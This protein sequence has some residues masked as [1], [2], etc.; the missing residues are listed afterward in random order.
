VQ[1]K[2]WQESVPWL[3][4]VR[5]S[6]PYWIVRSLS[7]IPIAAG[8]VLVLVGLTTGTRGAGVSVIGGTTVDRKP[9]HVEPGR[10]EGNS[11]GRGLVMA[12]V[13]ACVA[14]IGFFA[15]SVSLLGV[16]PARVLADQ[17]AAMAPQSTLPLTVSELRGRQVYAREGCAYCHTQQ[18]RYLEADIARFGAPTLAWEGRHDYPH[19]MGTRR[20]GPDLSRTGGTRTENWHFVHLYAPRSVVP[21]S[22][23]PSYAGLFE[24]APDRPSQEARDLVAYLESLGRARELAW[25][26]GD[27]AALAAAV[28]DKWARMSLEAPMLNAH[29]AKTRPAVE[30]PALPTGGSAEAGRA[31][32]IT[33]CTGCHGEQGRGDGPAAAWLTPAPTNL[34]ARAFTNEHLANVL[35]NGVHNTAMPARRELSPGDLADLVAL[36]NEMAARPTEVAADANLA[37][38]EDVYLR[39]CVECHGENGG[40]DGFAAADLPVRPGNFRGVQPTFEESLRILSNGVKGS[41]MAQWNDRLNADEMTAVA[42]YVRTFF[43]AGSEREERR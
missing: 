21:Q 6:R 43:N 2:L 17:T 12:Y 1:G 9:V 18:I 24:G 35:W 22:I 26:D 32:W 30:A 23:M 28:N 42:H 38:G 40:G 36:V 20:I 33:N 10:V 7:A 5:A 39:N 16:L 27:K 15:L 19:L 25:P 41:S 13:V 4:S 8:F 3:E 14:G 37:L 34:A 31:N 29:P 11:R